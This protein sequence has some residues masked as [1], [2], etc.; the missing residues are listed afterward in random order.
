MFS[1]LLKIT[2]L[3]TFSWNYSLGAL[4]AGGVVGAWQ[5]CHVTGWSTSIFFSKYYGDPHKL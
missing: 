1:R 4:A 3:L 5:K 2:I